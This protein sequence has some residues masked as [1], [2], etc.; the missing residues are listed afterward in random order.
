MKKLICI[1]LILI[2]AFSLTSCDEFFKSEKVTQQFDP[3]RTAANS[4]TEN[5]NKNTGAPTQT[6]ND[7]TDT[8]SPEATPEPE[9]TTDANHEPAYTED[10]TTE[11]VI[12]EEATE[13]EITTTPEPQTSPSHTESP[14]P[15]LT[16]P[17]VDP[18]LENTI[19]RYV[20]F[21][22]SIGAFEDHNSIDPF[23]IFEF[24]RYYDDSIRISYESMG[25]IIGDDGDEYELIIEK[26]DVNAL[27]S[28]T[29]AMFGREYSYENIQDYHPFTPGAEESFALENNEIVVTVKFY[30]GAGGPSPYFEFE[31]YDRDGANIIVN[32]IYMDLDE[33]DEPFPAKYYKMIIHEE[34][35]EYLL[36]SFTE[37]PDK[38]V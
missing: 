9:K 11:P 6:N 31:D 17:I 21:C 34:N 30:G 35:G 32:V 15:D 36:R 24:F 16:D 26:Y 23:A 7:K 33:N 8:N 28:I 3:D 2:T 10:V 27:N 1:I 14:I 12:T 20:D 13:P 4:T 37:N 5:T 19:L 25:E 18:R 29:R 38:Q 22:G